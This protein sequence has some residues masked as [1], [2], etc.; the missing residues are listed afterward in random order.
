MYQQPQYAPQMQQQPMMQQPMMQQA[1]PADNTKLWIGLA[2]V[3]AIAGALYWNSQRPPA[4]PLNPVTTG[5]NASG[6]TTNTLLPASGS[7]SGSSSGSYTPTPTVPTAAAPVVFSGP[8]V[9]RFNADNYLS[10]KVN[11]AVVYAESPTEWPDTQTVTLPNVRAGD[12]VDFNVRNAGGPGGFIGSWSWNGKA[13][14]VNPTVFPGKQVIAG[15]G[16]WGPGILN[17]FPGAQW[18]W[19]P[20]NCETCV[21]TFSWVAQ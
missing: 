7:S 3:V 1:P 11:G 19:S 13:Y 14:N 12:R 15:A 8:L 6:G 16:P 20:D 10:I 17:S 4:V 18:L 21:H 5:G 9:G 2:V